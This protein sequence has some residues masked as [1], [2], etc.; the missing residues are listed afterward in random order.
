MMDKA[1]CFSAAPLPSPLVMSM[2]LAFH[3]DHCE[4]TTQTKID[5]DSVM[6]R[7]RHCQAEHRLQPNAIEPGNVVRCAICPCEEL[8]VRKDFP[9]RLGMIIILVQ[10]ITSSITWYFHMIYWT[11]AILGASALLDFALYMWIG[12]VLQCYRCQSQY[13]G[14]EGLEDRD[15]F[16]LE[17]HE[18]YR[19]QQARMAE[20]EASARI[21]TSTMSDQSSP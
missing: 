8:F 1:V 10:M 19:Q 14:I 7:C 20:A 21:A 12:N 11:Y 2:N 3:C 17:T 4:R 16:S 15:A 9:Q 18:R 5:V 6:V 13:R